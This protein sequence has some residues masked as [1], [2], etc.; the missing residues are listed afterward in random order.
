MKMRISLTAGAVL[1]AVFTGAG[2]QTLQNTLPELNNYAWGFPVRTDEASSF[3]RIE[4]P[5]AVNQSSADAG[6]RDIAVYN[7]AGEPVSRIVERHEAETIRQEQR[8]DLPFAALYQDQYPDPDRIRMLFEQMG[9]G[10]RI[11]VVSE[12]AELQKISPP[13]SAYVIDTRSAEVAF[14]AVELAWPESL[15]GFMGR[16]TVEA[17]DNLEDWRLIGAGAVADLREESVAI[18]QR[19][20][21]ITATDSDFLRLSWSG[22]PTRWSLTAVHGVQR[23]ETPQFSRQLLL[24]DSRGRDDSDNGLLF[25]AGG[26]IRVDHINL[27]LPEVNTVISADILYWDD[28]MDRWHRAGGGTFHHIR[29]GDNSVTSEPLKIPPVRAARWKVVLS[30]GRQETPLALALG[31]F[32]DRLLFVAQGDP[33]YTLGVGR[34]SAG[35]ETFPEERIL[36]D[37]SIQELAGTSGSVAAASLGARFP[38]GGLKRELPAQPLAWRTI[39]LWGGLVIVVVFVGWMAARLLRESRAD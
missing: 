34:P 11:D 9:S 21:T 22:L 25:D 23:T 35:E 7:A 8:H 29:R 1:A 10:V 14:D 24:L 18:E 39:L 33:P 31:W 36:G 13:L 4:L 19:R 26:N 5:L 17:S 28:G 38:L 15:S 2:A 20:I 3:Y 16:V 30:R 37:R 6:L 32:P 12:G 27:E